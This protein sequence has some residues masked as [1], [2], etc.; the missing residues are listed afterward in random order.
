MSSNF[1]SHL[2]K[3]AKRSKRSL[4]GKGLF[5]GRKGLL[6]DTRSELGKR[7]DNRINKF[8]RGVTAK[9]FHARFGRPGETLDQY[10][11]RVRM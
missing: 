11:Q 8:T 6:V 10:R 4:F 2:E 7:V 3:C 5:V 1:Y 9:R